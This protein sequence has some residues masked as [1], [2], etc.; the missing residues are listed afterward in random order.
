[1]EFIFFAC[2]YTWYVLWISGFRHGSYCSLFW[3]WFFLCRLG[4]W[5]NCCLNLFKYQELQSC[6][7]VALTA[8]LDWQFRISFMFFILSHIQERR[9][10]TERWGRKLKKILGDLREKT[11]Y[12]KLKE[13][14]LDPTLWRTRFGRGY[15]HVARQATGWMNKISL[16]IYICCILICGAK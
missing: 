12:S 15:G 10:V 16:Y 11:G 13:E 4:Q 7:C 9:D 3:L 1:V 6:L 8:T 14:G 5:S 2:L